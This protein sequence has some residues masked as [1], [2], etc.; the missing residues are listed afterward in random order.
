MRKWIVRGI[1][2][3]RYQVLDVTDRKPNAPA[4]ASRIASEPVAH[5][6]AASPRMLAALHVAY[7]A[8]DPDSSA[9][10]AVRY[11]IAQAHQ[12]V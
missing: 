4:V 10:R 2:G 11:A 1:A 5:L 12:D 9:A 6:L 8:L 7:Q 3:G